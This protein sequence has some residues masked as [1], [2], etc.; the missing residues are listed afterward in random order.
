MTNA[1]M[2]SIALFASLHSV[3]LSGSNDYLTMT[4]PHLLA[5]TGTTHH[6]HYYF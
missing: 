4:P 1:L 3:V 2:E 5:C 6:H